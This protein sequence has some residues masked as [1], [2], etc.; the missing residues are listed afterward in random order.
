MLKQTSRFVCLNLSPSLCVLLSCVR[1]FVRVF[2]RVCLRACMRARACVCVV[3][4]SYDLAIILQRRSE[5]VVLVI[6]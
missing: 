5:L 6:V 2:V 4:S 3:S 1:V